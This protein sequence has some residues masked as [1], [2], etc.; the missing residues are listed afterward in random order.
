MINAIRPRAGRHPLRSR[1]VTALTCVMATGIIV[2]TPPAHAARVPAP[3]LDTADNFAVLASTRVANTGASIFTGNVGVSPSAVITGIIPGT[4][5]GTVHPGDVPAATARADLITGYND[6]ANQPAAVGLPT[7][8]GGRTVTPGLYNSSSGTFRLSGNLTLNAGGNPNQIFVFQTMPLPG[9]P[10]S[11]RLLTAPGSRVTLIGGAQACNV[12]WQVAGSARLG[13]GSNFAGSILA[14][15]SVNVDTGA[16]VNGRVLSVNG[17]VNVRA[18]TITRPICQPVVAP[19]ATTV[20]VTSPCSAAPGGPMTFTATV[21]ALNGTTPTGFVFFRLGRD[22]LGTALLVPSG[23]G[24]ARATLVNPVIPMGMDMAR[25]TATY[26]GTAT[27]I[28]STSNLLSQE[29]EEGRCPR[30]SRP[31]N[32]TNNNNNA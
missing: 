32:N 18:S 23:P 22:L 2:T 10:N 8:L 9:Q 26:P 21:R 31:V 16:T 13:L 28:P 29:I 12:F 24:T 1:L 5:N 20:T 11:N 6:A 27:L 17:E 7:Q 25:V 30:Q 15:N 19:G 3:P 4:V 14:L